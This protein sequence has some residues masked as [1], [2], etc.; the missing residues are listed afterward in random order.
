MAAVEVVDAYIS[1][2]PHPGRRL[3]HAEWGITVPAE[4]A[5]GAPLDVGL[6]I[7][8]GMLR[9][10]AVAV[11][12]AG[13]LDPWMLLWWNRQTRLV[14]F[15]CTQDRDIWVHADL[16]LFGMSPSGSPLGGAVDER[17]VDRLLGLVVEG[18]VAVRDYATRSRSLNAR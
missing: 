10:M 2:L 17:A 12:G 18:S 5:A 3:A 11:S 13:D 8:D 6:R 1:E 16:P 7:A 15:G 9:A 4:A 14:R